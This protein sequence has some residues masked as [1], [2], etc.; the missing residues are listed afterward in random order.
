MSTQ[1]QKMHGVFNP[2]FEGTPQILALD[3]DECFPE[4]Y[5]TIAHPLASRPWELRYHYVGNYEIGFTRAM[6][7]WS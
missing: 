2:R 3:F 6:K 5:N 1:Y 7:H 4:I